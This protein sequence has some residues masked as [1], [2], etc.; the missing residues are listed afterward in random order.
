MMPNDYTLLLANDIAGLG[1]MHGAATGEA[2]GARSQ[3]AP[4]AT[5]TGS[6]QGAHAFA[7]FRLGSEQRAEMR[8]AIQQMQQSEQAMML[9]MFPGL[10]QFMN[11]LGELQSVAVSLDENSE[12][13]RF[14]LGLNF[15]GEENAERAST[16]I[17]QTIPAAAG[18]MAGFAQGD[19]EAL[20]QL[21]AFGA[22]RF[23]HSG[24]RAF[25]SMPISQEML[26]QAAEAVGELGSL[27]NL[28]HMFPQGGM[29]QQP[30][31]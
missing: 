4:L 19:P 22:L 9:M 17:N 10:M 2:P 12:G 29:G 8:Q 31:W 25:L 14:N 1:Q 6:A 27:D 11:E 23:G 3:G 24:S 18:M 21:Q 5:M 26:D 20:A 30:V 15:T 16:Y 28:Q 7:A 13:A